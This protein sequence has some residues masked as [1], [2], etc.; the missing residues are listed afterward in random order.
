MGRLLDV[1]GLTKHFTVRRGLLAWP[2]CA[3]SAAAAAAAAAAAVVVP[4]ALPPVP[5][6]PPAPPGVVVPEPVLQRVAS[7]A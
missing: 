1:A 2:A 6:A 3:L 4:P 5:A 7:N